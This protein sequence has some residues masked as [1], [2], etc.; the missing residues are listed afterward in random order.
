LLTVSE[1]GGP[2]QQLV[3]IVLDAE[4][5][6][7]DDPGRRLVLRQALARRVRVAASLA[8]ALHSRHVPIRLLL[9]DSV[10][11][12]AS[13]TAGR[14]RLL[15]ALAE[16]PADGWQRQSSGSPLKLAGNRLT[17]WVRGEPSGDWGGDVCVWIDRGD[18]GKSHQR[19][20]FAGGRVR[21]VGQLALDAQ[22]ARFWRE[23]QH[24][25]VAA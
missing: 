22:L 24:G 13:G 10:M 11:A 15:T 16:V 17:L 18:R 19:H 9:G 20:A 1:R 21:I 4:L 8:M 25:N 2:E 14:R 6:A 23:A 3:D 5:A 12:I 7:S